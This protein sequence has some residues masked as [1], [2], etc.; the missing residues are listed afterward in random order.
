MV[1]VLVS[2]QCGPGSD[3]RPGVIIIM[4]V[5][6]VVGSHFASVLYLLGS[7]VFLP[8]QKQRPLNSNYIWRQ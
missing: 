3:L 4:R 5:E 2:Y 8:P 1:K 7:L 6:F